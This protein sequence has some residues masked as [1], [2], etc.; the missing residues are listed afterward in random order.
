MRNRN[1][2]HTPTGRP[3]GTKKTGGRRRGT[4][5]KA[6]REVKA[7]A[8]KLVGDLTYQRNLQ[9]RMRD[10]TAGSME[11]LMHHYAHGKP[12]DTIRILDISRLSTE[13]LQRIYDETDPAKE[14]K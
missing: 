4:L 2:A 1:T 13:T 7:F 8:G 12:V 6:T 5:N 11:P 14:A 3:K 10:G 9:Q